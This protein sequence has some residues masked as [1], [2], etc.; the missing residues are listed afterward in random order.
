MMV[1]LI[2]NTMVFHSHAR[3][4]SRKVLLGMQQVE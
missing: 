3:N 4:H 1:L 2:T